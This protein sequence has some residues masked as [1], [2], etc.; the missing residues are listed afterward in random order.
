MNLIIV[1]AVALDGTI[2]DS[3]TNSLPW[4]LPSDLRNFKAITLNKT[5]V[6]GRRTFESI[7]NRPLPKRR[8]IVI[9]SDPQFTWRHKI[10]TYA[11]VS[12]AMVGESD[13]TDLYVIGGQRVFEE[14]MDLVPRT[15]YITVVKKNVGGDVK[16]PIEGH[17]FLSNLLMHTRDLTL[18]MRVNHSPWIEENGVEFCFNEFSAR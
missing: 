13:S 16:F 10:T 17:K 2:G 11:S 15:F 14:A 18:Y 6:M 12:E 8:N 5:V 9:T 3:K 4:D 7:G 1:A